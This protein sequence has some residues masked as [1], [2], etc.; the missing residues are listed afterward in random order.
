[1][2]SSPPQMIISLPV[3]IALWLL[4]A[5]GAF[6]WTSGFQAAATGSY[7]TSRGNPADS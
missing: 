6:A 1:M 2:P 4:R 3:Q 5:L 7:D